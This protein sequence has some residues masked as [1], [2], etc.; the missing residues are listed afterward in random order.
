MLEIPVAE[1]TEGGFLQLDEVTGL[2]LKAD[3][4]VLSACQTGQ[5]RLHN[6]EA[7]SG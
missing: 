1:A 4:V 7:V 3:L 2:R 6:A 5:G